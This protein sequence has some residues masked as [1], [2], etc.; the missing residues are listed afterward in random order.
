MSGQN[1]AWKQPGSSCVSRCDMCRR[2]LEQLPRTSNVCALSLL[3]IH[4]ALKLSRISVS[5]N[6][7]CRDSIVDVLEI[8]RRQFHLCA[9]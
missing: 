1:H 8:F 2:W 7:N 4:E 9:S 3:A 5:L 6:G